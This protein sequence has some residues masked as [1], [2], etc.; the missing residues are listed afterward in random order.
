MDTGLA[1]LSPGHPAQQ[2]DRSQPVMGFRI[3]FLVLSELEFPKPEC[4][5][6]ENSFQAD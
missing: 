5:K 4:D 6:K 3:I 2:L 1:Y